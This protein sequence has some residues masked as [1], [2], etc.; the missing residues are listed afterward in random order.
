VQLLYCLWVA[1]LCGGVFLVIQGGRIFREIEEAAE[2]SRVTAARVAAGGCLIQM[3]N[4][5]IEP[6][7]PSGVRCA[8][9]C[10]RSTYDVSLSNGRRAMPKLLVLRFGPTERG[11]TFSQGALPCSC[12]AGLGY[13]CSVSEC[14][15][16]FQARAFR[17][18][19][20]V[21]PRT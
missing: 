14:G 8:P 15:V 19:G 12:P 20:F 10:R 3:A 13:P 17:F 18:F 2:K 5:F 21:S 11:R 16:V 9:G 6:R 7:T 4:F 1:F